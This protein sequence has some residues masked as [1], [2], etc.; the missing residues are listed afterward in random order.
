MG[1]GVEGAA[2]P[3]NVSHTCTICDSWSGCRLGEDTGSPGGES[4]RALF[5]VFGP[6][7]LPPLPA[8]SAAGLWLLWFGSILPYPVLAFMSLDILDKS[9]SGA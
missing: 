8:S 2:L 6:H 7:V 1:M 3:S 5:Y 4:R 9:G